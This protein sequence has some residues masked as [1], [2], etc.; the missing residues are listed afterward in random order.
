MGCSCDQLPVAGCQ[1]PVKLNGAKRDGRSSPGD[2]DHEQIPE[3]SARVGRT[4]R[5]LMLE[6]CRLR[7]FGNS[8]SGRRGGL[9]GRRR[10]GVVAPMA[11]SGSIVLIVSDCPA[12]ANGAVVRRYLNVSNPRMIW[13]V[14]VLELRVGGSLP[15][16]MG[17]TRRRKRRKT[18]PPVKCVTRYSIVATAW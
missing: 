18:K 8:A 13:A 6:E 7:L 15:E 2:R 4:W 1:L 16:A 17:S 10:S 11:M 12:A 3:E 5:I 14:A 9:C